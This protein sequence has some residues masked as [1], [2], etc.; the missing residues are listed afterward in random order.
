MIRTHEMC[1]LVFPVRLTLIRHLSYKAHST[2]FSV[3]G[4]AI[5]FDFVQITVIVLMAEF[6]PSIFPVCL[7]LCILSMLTIWPPFFDEV[8]I[9]VNQLVRNGIT[10]VSMKS[11]EGRRHRRDDVIGIH[12]SIMLDLVFIIEQLCSLETQRAG[13]SK[14]DQSALIHFHTEIT[15]QVHGA[16]NCRCTTQTVTNQQD[17]ETHSFSHVQKMHE[18][19]FEE[20]RFINLAAPILLFFILGVAF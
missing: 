2:E 15:Y 12:Q 9:T 16:K 1:I 20:F 13:H 19:I 10:A 18:E 17:G 5:F 4:N 11:H 7:A 3:L 8:F 6:N 14:G